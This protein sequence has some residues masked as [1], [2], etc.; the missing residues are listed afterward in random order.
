MTLAIDLVGSQVVRVNGHSFQLLA[1][2]WVQNRIVGVGNL[3]SALPH[4]FLPKNFKLLLRGYLLL[5][6]ILIEHL[7]L[8]LLLLW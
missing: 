1:T 6:F 5:L 4:S 7:A 8:L 2:W 3:L